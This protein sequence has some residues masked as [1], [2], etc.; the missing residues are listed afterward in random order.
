MGNLLVG[1]GCSGALRC[2]HETD[3]VGPEGVAVGH[4]IAVSRS[5]SEGLDGAAVDCCNGSERATDPGDCRDL[6]WATAP[7]SKGRWRRRG[8][9]AAA[10]RRRIAVDHCAATPWIL[11]AGV[12]SGSLHRDRK[13]GS[14]RPGRSHRSETCHSPTTPRSKSLHQHTRA[15]QRDLAVDHC[16]IPV[17]H[18]QP[19]PQLTLTTLQ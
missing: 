8:W 14:R 10:G 18:I 3:I 2:R 11:M 16:T 9:W 6:Q 17:Q 15:R 12:C 19:L 5:P 13:A 7:G 1:G 4:C